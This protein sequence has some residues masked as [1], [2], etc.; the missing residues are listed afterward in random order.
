M[1]KLAAPKA[2]ETAN[3]REMIR[4]AR[5]LVDGSSSRE[6]DYS[7]PD[8]LRERVVVGARVR[9]SLRQRKSTGTVAGIVEHSEAEADR[10]RLRDLDSVI[11]DIPALTPQLLDLG[12]WISKVLL[13]ADGIGD[14]RPAA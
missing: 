12:R 13:H 9:V 8:A 14:A 2:L 11:D 5:V 4:A 1:R 7:I 6:F 3:S 10:M